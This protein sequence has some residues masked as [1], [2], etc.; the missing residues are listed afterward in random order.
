M[1]KKCLKCGRSYEN[2]AKFCGFCGQDIAT[3]STLK[4]PVSGKN[5]SPD[6]QEDIIKPDSLSNIPENLIGQ[7]AGEY[8]ITGIIGKGGMGWVYSGE[9]PII[10]KKVAVKVL[11][12]KYSKDTD[13]VQAFK[14]EAKAA[15]EI[16]SEHIIDI[17]SFGQ[18]PSG[19]FFFVMELLEG[20]NLGDF[21][22][23]HS[24]LSYTEAYE[25]LPQILLALDAA[26]KKN[27]IHRD[28]KP[29][30]IFLGRNSHGDF[31]VKLLDFGIA[32]FKEEGYTNNQTVQGVIKGSPLY[33]SPEQCRGRDITTSSDIYSFGVILYRCFK[34][35]EPF[36]GTTP[37]DVISGHLKD[38]P[39]AISDEHGI[40][41]KLADI[42]FRCLS[43]EPFERF[44]S[45]SSLNMEIRQVLFDINSEPQPKNRKT[46]FGPILFMGI[47]ALLGIGIYFYANQKKSEKIETD[48]VE[49]LN[50]ETLHV[51]SAHPPDLNSE[52]EEGFKRYMN[53]KFG[54]NVSIKWVTSKDELFLLRMRLSS[55]KKNPN[56][57]VDVMLGGGQQ[58]HRKLASSNCVSINGEKKSCSVKINPDPQITENIPSTL[59]GINLIDPQKKWFATALSGFGIVC[60]KEKL[61][62]KK[63]RLPASWTDLSKRT[64]FNSL[65]SADPTLSSSTLMIYEMILQSLG[66]KKGWEVITGI[67]SNIS[68]HFLRSSSGIM[69]HL[70]EDKNAVCGILIDFLY[71]LWKTESD[72]SLTQKMIF[73]L[74]PETAVF[75]PDPVSVLRFSPR[76]ELAEKFV[77]FILGE[78][79]NIFI[80]PP[81]SK[82]GPVKKSIPRLPV[83]SKLYSNKNA[84]F[85]TNPFEIKNKIN[86]RPDI[87]TKR[88]KLLSILLRSAVIDTHTSLVRLNKSGKLHSSTGNVRAIEMPL[89]E[90]KFMEKALNLSGMDSLSFE[91]MR[92][93]WLNW[94]H[95]R[96]R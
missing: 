86:F 14:N 16:R 34:G 93:N 42:I 56:K 1:T 36:L 9:H 76:K 13:I 41:K 63:I 58:L 46:W 80:L 2:N 73:I 81:G 79:Q 96:Y 20:E 66:W 85:Y 6:N 59:Q 38:P 47:T 18:L 26:H 29:E 90:K 22:K 25:I 32:K 24:T 21:L 57:M 28:L 60:N 40:D 49:N 15:N 39:P 62:A 30:N 51:L 44:E 5:I 75:T 19:N 74:P 35:H 89:S 95:K 4:M 43:K 88:K 23:K 92:F 3:S 91:K 71:F 61:A 8:I 27:I 45:A 69:H 54:R 7:M 68:G 94:F 12:T 82:Q 17:F 83:N 64:F 70:V 10:G 72:A 33:M 78:G 55:T 67:S 37:M 50:I 11:K 52:Y 31:H 65:V 84:V 48:K 77:E 87:A 53:R